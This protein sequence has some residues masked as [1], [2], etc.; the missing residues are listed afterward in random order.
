M[1]VNYSPGYT[2]P[3]PEGHAFPMGKF[4]A[5]RH[6]LER[7]AII[8]PEDVVEPGEAAWEDLALVHTPAYLHK[9]R[10]GALEPAE[11]RRLGLPWSPALVRRSRLAV[12]G[13]VNAAWMALEDGVAANLAG[14]T[15]HAFPDHGE[16]FCVLNDVGV[17][18]RLLRRGGWIRRALVIDLDVHQGNGTAAVF[19]DDPDTFT[20][21]MHGE[22]NYPFRE[23]PSD[24]DVGLP[25]GTGDEGYE[26]AL[27]NIFPKRCRDRVRTSCSTS[28]GSMS[29]RQIVS[30]ASHSRARGSSRGIAS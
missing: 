19:A 10:H 9:L 14:G 12:R 20:F 23:T 1:R 27:L 28:E 30:D 25:D 17:A 16:G 2:V 4:A 13:T 26:A 7:D 6:T 3:L 29:S 15:H 24:L 21:S 22:G 5:L 18:V 11:V 8:S